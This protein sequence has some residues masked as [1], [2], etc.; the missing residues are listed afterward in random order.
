MA[1]HVMVVVDR[2]TTRHGI[3]VWVVEE[4]RTMVIW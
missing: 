1:L 3:F 4:N 2:L